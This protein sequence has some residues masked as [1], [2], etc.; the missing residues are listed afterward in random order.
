MESS[1]FEASNRKNFCSYPRCAG[2][3]LNA[4]PL[5]VVR[6]GNDV[7]LDIRPEPRLT[8]GSNDDW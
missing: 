8:F 3:Q 4:E 1:A 7:P 2:R 5:V 6:S